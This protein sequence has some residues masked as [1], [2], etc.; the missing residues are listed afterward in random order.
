MAACKS[1]GPFPHS[2]VILI[3]L[4]EKRGILHTE[5]YKPPHV[6]FLFAD[7][8]LQEWVVPSHDVPVNVGCLYT[9]RMVYIRMETLVWQLSPAHN[10]AFIFIYVNV[11]YQ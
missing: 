2:L 10:W 3:D 5:F 9:C 6:W 11:A 1:Y 7:P 4:W 8:R